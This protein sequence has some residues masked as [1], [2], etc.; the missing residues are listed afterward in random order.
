V[1]PGEPGAALLDRD[2][3]AHRG[4]D[5]R[6]GASPELAHRLRA[7]V[8][9]GR[10]A[11]LR[12]LYVPDAR[13]EGAVPGQVLHER[14]ADAILAVLGGWWGSPT[15]GVVDWQVRLAGAGVELSV[16][17]G[18]DAGPCRQLHWLHLDDEGRIRRHIVH[19]QRPSS[20][21]P[22]PVVPSWLAAAAHRA[23]LA[24]HGQSGAGLERAVLASGDVVVVKHLSAASDWIMRATADP[25][26]EAT[27][28]LSGVLRDLPGGL[29]DPVVAAERAGDGWELVQRDVAPVLLGAGARLTREDARRLL[30]ALDALHRRF[31]GAALPDACSLADRAAMFS[32]RTAAAERDGPDLV[33]KLIGRGWE[34]FC[35]GPGGEVVPAVRALVDDPAPL[36][37]ALERDGT[38]LIHGDAK[39]ANLGLRADG[40][41]AIDWGMACRAPA[42]VELAWY[43]ECGAPAVDATRGDL[44]ADWRDARASRFEPM[45]LRLALLFEVVLSGWSWALFAAESPF[46]AE[47]ARSAAALTWWLDEAGRTLGQWSP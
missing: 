2:A 9:H 5:G 30:V 31:E 41:V 18:T 12:D 46:P 26:R 7:A 16:E 21:G 36:V 6:V 32:P 19:S 35:A 43:L 39:P 13:L 44:L 23:P 27:L 45:R 38:T 20:L 40:V 37:D 11:A 14:G 24:G 4:H 3:P 42:E 10:V 17:W 47:R 1:A 8:E 28:W 34:H 15:P 25:G 22:R 33:P 29:D